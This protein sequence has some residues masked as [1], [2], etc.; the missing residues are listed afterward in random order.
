MT[1]RETDGDS[2]Y[3]SKEAALRDYKEHNFLFTVIGWGM[4]DT[5]I[6]LVEE[7]FI[8]L[9]ETK[10]P[11]PEDK[12]E[13]SK[14]INELINLGQIKAGYQEGSVHFSS[15]SRHLLTDLKDNTKAKQY[16]VLVG[17]PKKED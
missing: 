6:E 16:V 15:L 3:D 11:V 1:E 5:P 13:A 12:E 7:K 4:S 2:L 8:L 14:K 17:I 10:I 9:G